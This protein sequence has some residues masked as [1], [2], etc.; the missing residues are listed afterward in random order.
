MSGVGSTGLR[1][2]VYVDAFNVYYGGAELCGGKHAP[3]WRW[4]DLPALALSLVNPML[5]PNA[6]FARFAYC[7]APRGRHGPTSADQ[8]N[9]IEALLYKT[10]TPSPS[11]RAPTFDVRRPAS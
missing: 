5:W 1:V 8:E 7:T 4:L 10:G 6:S 9:Y 2:G 3:G 11:S